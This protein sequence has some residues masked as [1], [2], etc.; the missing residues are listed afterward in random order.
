MK[1]QLALVTAAFALVGAC[2]PP[3]PST[4]AEDG[5]LLD[6]QTIVVPGPDKVKLSY[7]RAGDADGQRVIFVHGTPG[8]ADGW[9]DFLL[10]V[11]SGSEFLAVDRPGF[12]RTSPDRAEPHL[13]RQA[14][15]IAALL[16]ERN[17]R[18]TILVGHSLG[19]PIIARVAV[20]HPGQV[21]GLLILAGAFDPS[22]EKIHPLQ[23]VGELW[24]VRSLLPRAMRNANRELLPLKQELE[25]LVP[26]LSQ[27]DVP[28]IVMHG[29]ADQLVPVANVAFMQA[30][31]G[32]S[33]SMDT[34]I[35][36]GADHFLPWKHR[37]AIELALS[38]LTG[39]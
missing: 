18:K 25:Q 6:R 32:S 3:G 23:P 1:M 34:D 15:A 20:D 7:L 22:L 35:I 24:G 27:I 11:P 17:G 21:G 14:D 9:R 26:L 39:R 2:G 19:G 13:A 12:G 38:R 37:P 4:S 28:V 16:V 31:F 29:S 8:E 36:V 33:S 30:H 10:N 5:K